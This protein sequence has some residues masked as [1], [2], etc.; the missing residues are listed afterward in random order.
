VRRALKAVGLDAQVQQRKP[1]KSRKH[2]LARPEV[3]SKVM[4][5]GLLMIFSDKTK[6]NRFNSNNRL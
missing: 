2:V 3:C 5:I 1:F 6:I 4:K